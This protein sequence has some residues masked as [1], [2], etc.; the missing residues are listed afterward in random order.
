MISIGGTP[1][2][3][4]AGGAPWAS[5]AIDAIPGLR[6]QQ[7]APRLRFQLA[8][9]EVR[10]QNDGAPASDFNRCWAC[11]SGRNPRFVDC[12]KEA[13]SLVWLLRHVVVAIHWTCCCFVS[14]AIEYTG[15]CN[16]NAFD[17]SF[18]IKKV[19]YNIIP[20]S[21]AHRPTISII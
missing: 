2:P 20:R 11:W 10:F 12:E 21:G 17:V 16:Y 3:I 6:F 14:F 7:V 9:T 15:A 5:I 1:P 4:S 8:V 13:S 18:V 19:I